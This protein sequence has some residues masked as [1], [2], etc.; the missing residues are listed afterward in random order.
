MT[1]K[2]LVYRKRDG[3]PQQ[4]R[5]FSAAVCK[6]IIN[7]Q[8]KEQPLTISNT[9]KA[10]TTMTFLFVTITIISGCG[11]NVPLSGRI[12]F[13]DTGEPLPLG[14]IGFTDG[15]IQARSDIDAD[16][17]Y[18]LGFLSAGDGLP[19]G[20]YKIYIQAVRVEMQTGPDTDGDGQPDIIDR[21]EIPL[22]AQKY[23]SP[24]SSGLTFTADGKTKTFDI[25]VEKP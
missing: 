18:T 12:T 7:F 16:G 25:T 20:E 14:T 17:K 8:L 21:K 4:E 5:I 24:E 23:A 22:I 10:L 13:S 6:L 15:K 2:L 9:M 1:D 3:R 11:Q 19:K